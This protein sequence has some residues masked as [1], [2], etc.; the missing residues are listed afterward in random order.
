MTPEQ[1]EQVRRAL[2]AVARAEDG[3]E[4]Q[5]LPPDVA[6]RLDDVLHELVA[7]RTGRS[8]PSAAAG[9]AADAPAT[10]DELAARRRRRWQ[11]ALVA[12][13]AVAVIAAAGGAVATRGFGGGGGAERSSAGGASSDRMASGSAGIAPPTASGS[14]PE[15]G[16]GKASA[17]RVPPLSS[18]TLARDVRRVVAAG[19]ARYLA[20]NGL[21]DV[22]T[23]P[24]PDSARCGRPDAPRGAD[25]VAVRL[26]GQPATL[27]LAPVRNGTR[28]ARVYSCAVPPAL[29]STLTVPASG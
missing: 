20:P 12:A 17:L 9:T 2:A 18:R 6:D 29:L 1:E 27:A 16:S 11:H 7:G 22:P 10:P 5:G 8:A 24:R 26:D 15:R 23:L 3:P 4:T 13:A 19:P 25:L 14:T 28:V 21:R